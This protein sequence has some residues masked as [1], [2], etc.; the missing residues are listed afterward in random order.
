MYFEQSYVIGCVRKSQIQQLEHPLHYIASIFAV[1]VYL[2][3][4]DI[5]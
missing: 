3:A 4:F 5:N 2:K 1:I